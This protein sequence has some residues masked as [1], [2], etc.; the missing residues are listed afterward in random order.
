MSVSHPGPERTA[1]LYT[2]HKEHTAANCNAQRNHQ[3]QHPYHYRLI[4][5]LW[6]CVVQKTTDQL[7]YER[8]GNLSDCHSIS[9]LGRVVSRVQDLSASIRVP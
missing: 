5:S 6:S 9:N 4:T 7:A 3:A 1:S 2:T 8:D